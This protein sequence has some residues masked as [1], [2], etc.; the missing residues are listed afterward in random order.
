MAKIICP[1]CS[2]HFEPND[3]FPDDTPTQGAAAG[4]SGNSFELMIEGMFGSCRVKAVN[5]NPE[6][7]YEP[8]LYPRT[9][10]LLI[11]KVAV[12]GWT[13]DFEFKDFKRALKVPIEAKQQLGSGST[14]E[15]LAHTIDLLIKAA[16]RFDTPFYW[17]AL[18]GQGWGKKMMQTVQNKI[19]DTN[20]RHKLKGRVLFNETNLQR[21]IHALVDRG[22]AF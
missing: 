19:N 14:D 6:F 8:Q 12:N 3:L 2:H 9:D 21:A 4:R 7:H 17:L 11:R 1:N 16:Q 15:K 5:D 13:V 18:G 10:K 20:A 22:T